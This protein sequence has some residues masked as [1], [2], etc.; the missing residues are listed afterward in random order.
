MIVVLAQPLIHRY[1]RKDWQTIP[2]MT[3]ITVVLVTLNI[4]MYVLTYI[5]THTYIHTQ[6]H[7]WVVVKIRVPFLGTLNIRCRIILGTQKGTII[8]TTT[9]YVYTYCIHVQ[10]SC[11]CTLSFW[12]T[13]GDPLHKQ[14]VPKGFKDT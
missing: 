5:H 2:A 9:Q 13:I 10:R 7:I 11:G 1:H 12:L 4:C 6:T 3:V 8:L 14:Q